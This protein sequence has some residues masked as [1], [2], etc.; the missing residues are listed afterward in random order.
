MS[1]DDGSRRRDL[2]L[3]LSFSVKKRPKDQKEV[4]TLFLVLPPVSDEGRLSC[5]N[6]PPSGKT[7]YDGTDFLSRFYLEGVGVRDF[8]YSLRWTGEVRNFV[9]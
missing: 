7:D 8:S 5:F 1:E 4:S 2:R 3:L 9:H 6:T